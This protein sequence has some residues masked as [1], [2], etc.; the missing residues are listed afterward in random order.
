M[1]ER[2]LLIE[3]L[4]ESVVLRLTSSR[5]GHVHIEMPLGDWSRLV[6]NRGPA[7]AVT[8]EEKRLQ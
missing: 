1:S 7:V 6:S 2:M 8:V 5:D 3:R 4:S